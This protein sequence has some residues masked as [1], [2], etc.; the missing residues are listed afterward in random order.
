MNGKALFSFAFVYCIFFHDAKAQVGYIGNWSPNCGG[1]GGSINIV[2]ND[3]IKIN[4]NDNNLYITARLTPRAD[5]YDIY[6]KDI[7]E[8]MNGV[9]DWANISLEKPIAKLRFQGSTASMDWI[10]FYDK[11]KHEYVWPTQTDFNIF[12]KRTAKIKLT[13]CHL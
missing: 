13:K 9:V 4:V 12:S 5:E 6:F 1:F 7:I 2:K 3:D 10:G 11:T 8:S